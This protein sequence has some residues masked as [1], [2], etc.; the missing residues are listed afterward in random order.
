MKMYF[1]Y[2]LPLSISIIHSCKDSVNQQQEKTEKTITISVIE[3]NSD[4]KCVYS[5]SDSDRRS[6]YPFNQADKIEIISYPVRRDNLKSL[7]AK[8]A[9]MKEV[10]ERIVLNQVQSDSIFSIFSN[11][12][13]KKEGRDVA[14]C[15]DPRHSI[16]F[17]KKKK[18]F[19]A[20]EICFT[21]NQIIHTPRVNVGILCDN[22][23]NLLRDLFGQFG[24]KYGLFGDK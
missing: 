2:V 16:L 17:Y 18:V 4:T 1:L 3:K 5:K 24:I 22:K 7:L 10:K 8:G 13:S 21:C 23:L 9:T 19:A 15:F 14:A 12:S 20:I 6:V 11:Y